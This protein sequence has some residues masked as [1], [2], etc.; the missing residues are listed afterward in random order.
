MKKLQRKI[1]RWMV[2]EN[3]RIVKFYNHITRLVYLLIVVVLTLSSFWIRSPTH[4]EVKSRQ[5]FSNF[6]KVRIQKAIILSFKYTALSGI[7]F[8]YSTS[9]VDLNPRSTGLKIWAK[10]SFF[11]TWS[12]IIRD[13]K[14]PCEFWDLMV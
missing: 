12:S 4:A 6:L 13:S 7:C 8:Y 3:Q 14:V 10:N 2:I 5:I 11:D 9:K 1:R